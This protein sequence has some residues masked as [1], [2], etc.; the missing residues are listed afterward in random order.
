MGP[1]SVRIPPVVDI[2]LSYA[3]EDEPRARTIAAALERIGWSVWW[4]RHIPHGQHFADYIQQQLDAARCI[5]VLWSRVSVVSQ[6]VRDEAAEG[7][8][9]RLVPALLEPVRQPIGFRQLQAADL[10]DW[11]GQ[12]SH[13]EFARM[14][15]SIESLVPLPVKAAATAATVPPAA[16][17]TA[18]TA[19]PVAATAVDRT[20]SNASTPSAAFSSREWVEEA[21]RLLTGP[22]GW[23]VAA[24]VLAIVVA[25][26]S[27]PRL[28][29]EAGDV[30]GR[31]TS[32]DADLVGPLRDDTQDAIVSWVDGKVV[33]DWPAE[34][35]KRDRA[36]AAY[37]NDADPERAAKYGFRAGQTPQLAWRW[38]RDNPVGFDG[39]PFVL[40]KTL[41]DLDPNHRD[42]SLRAIARIWK[43]ETIVP[44]G[45]ASPATAWTFDHIG[46]SPHP[47]DY[48]AGVAR[49]AGQR[50]A[51]LPF[52]LAFE[53]PR[54]FEAL[55]ESE[56]AAYDARLLAR[57]DLPDNALRIAAL[58]ASMHE[59]NWEIDRPSFGSP[60]ELDRVFFSCAAC[61]V[62][63]VVVAGRMKTLPGMPNTE[64]EAQYFSK[65]LMLTGAALIEAGF[66][67]GSTSPVNP[68]AIATNLGAVRAL[69]TEMMEKARQRPESLYG[70]SPV[71]VARG[72]IQ[73]LTVA[74]EFPKVIEDLISLSVKTHFV[75]QVVARNNAYHRPRP[76][77]F[78]DR[79][80]RMDAFGIAAGLVAW[81]TR[82]PDNSFLEL[83]R[84]DNP[85]NPIF[86]GFTKANGLPA[87]IPGLIERITDARAAGERL[88]RNIPAWAP[89][90]PAPVD[91]MSVA[92]G[93][94][95]Y[96]ANWDGNQG[97]SSRT[98]ESGAA[99][100]GDPRLINVR[101]HEPLS[102][103]T[104]NLPPSPFPFG[105]DLERAREGK[106]LF[107]E[108]CA[109]CHTTRNQ[110]IYAASTLGVDPNRS[111][112]I[113]SVSRYGL[114]AMMMEACYIHE[115][116]HKGQPGADWCVPKGDWQARLDEYM[117]DTPRRVV[118]GTNG[119]KADAL[120]GIWA[121]APYLH[122]GSVPTLGQLVC[123]QTRPSRFLRGNAH[124]DDE[125]VGFEWAARPRARYGPDD[126]MLIKEYDTTVPGNANTGHTAGAELCPDTANLDPVADRA[127]I[128]KRILDS[129]VGSLLAYLKTL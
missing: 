77:V 108:R 112:A 88:F 58:K 129:K 15:R 74:E 24:V 14:V 73:T 41:L 59:E 81:H 18:T 13:A 94:E 62:G 67:P 25:A 28:A 39:I 63:R 55:S 115:L 34:I 68:A 57:R 75:Y 32:T 70:S 11:D 95:R 17:E 85:S 48:V 43:R 1:R 27:W 99:I 42:P 102:L 72:K 60:G 87:D 76:D 64:I 83:V 104:D 50:T 101:I 47:G 23:A 37:L 2:F 36:I 8:N 79:P 6:F 123:P 78:E 118:G 40:F 97:A 61:H 80:G 119:Y 126:T 106:A 10:C 71:D 122:N 100:T 110:M 31:S 96:H 53:N 103:F 128:T 109:P 69:Y 82:R 120:H 35:E 84:S 116:N 51:P 92:W 114:A 29:S 30:L 49:P 21:R 7:L 125:L 124:Y 111:I 44:S 65:L 9:G 26:I 117:R 5:I 4:D 46:L 113:T 127:S 20:S 105:V 89:A 22:R 91:I 107:R 52:G 3:R 66:S 45:S 19:G 54:S 90:V 33:N 16:A 38:F 12:S 86:S 93:S 98:V 56:T 121:Q